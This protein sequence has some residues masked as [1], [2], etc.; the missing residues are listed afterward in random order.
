MPCLVQSYPTYVR[1]WRSQ[2]SQGRV[3]LCC[4][5]L[6]LPTKDRER[7]TLVWEARGWCVFGSG[8]LASRYIK[9]CWTWRQWPGTRKQKSVHYCLSSSRGTFHRAVWRDEHASKRNPTS[10]CLCREEGGGR[11]GNQRL[12]HMVLG[13]IVCLYREFFQSVKG[14]SVPRVSV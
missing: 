14:V 11:A 8:H 6:I 3:W 5:T 9:V 7:G 10:S 2:S 13:S 4:I 1:C 12:S